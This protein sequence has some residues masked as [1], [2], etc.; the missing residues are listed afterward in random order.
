MN[1]KKSLAALLALVLILSL[2]AGCAYNPET[3]MTVDGTDISAGKYLYMQWLAIQTALSKNPELVTSGKDAYTGEVEGQP[4]REFIAAE[5]LRNVKKLVF[6]DNEFERLGLS[7]TEEDENY[8]TQMAQYNWQ[9]NYGSILMSNGISFN[10]FNEICSTL[11]KEHYIVLALYG[12]DGEK[13][14]PEQTLTDYFTKNYTRA[15]YIELPSEGSFALGTD[16]FAQIKAA[17]EALVSTAREKDSLKEGYLAHY[18]DIYTL[19]GTADVAT[20]EL[21]DTTVKADALI[22]TDMDSSSFGEGIVTAVLGAGAGAYGLADDGKKTIVYHVKG[23]GESD[24]LDN[25]RD[26]L[27]GQLAQDE[28]ENEYCESITDDYE[29]TTDEKAAAYYS[30]DKAV[31]G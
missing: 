26:T 10:S 21:Y 30:I 1:R 9:N 14:I 20:E 4:A 5:T 31:L 29:I 8:N 27:V 23:L 19:A 24:T 25:Y 16:T 11:Y 2:F 15:D 6:L 18:N 12:K 7:F 22:Y 13:E 17:G 3:V 28:F